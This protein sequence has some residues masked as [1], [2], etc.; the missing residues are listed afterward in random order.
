MSLRYLPIA[1]I[2]AACLGS[3]GCGKSVPDPTDALRAF[4][5]AAFARASSDNRLTAEFQLEP[6]RVR[7]ASSDSLSAPR[8]AEV[9]VN[10]V[11]RVIKGD[12]VAAWIVEKRDRVKG[13]GKGRIKLAREAGDDGKRN[14]VFVYAYQD[15]AWSLKE[16]KCNGRGFMPD[17]LKQYFE[18]AAPARPAP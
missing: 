4:A 1:I 8:M 16:Q 17:E 9:V 12:D 14:F 18:L 13:G 2:V 11:D 7:S 3:T 15:G 6:P 10:G 5:A